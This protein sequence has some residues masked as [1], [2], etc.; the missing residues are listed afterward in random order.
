MLPRTSTT[1]SRPLRIGCLCEFPS[2]TGGEHSLLTAVRALAGQLEP[3]WIAP[4]EGRLAEA[5][6]AHGW[7][8][9][10][11]HVRDAAGRRRPTPDLLRELRRLLEGRPLDLLHANSLSMGRLTGA[12]AE[13]ILLPRTAHLRD[14][15]TL[16]RQAV[17]DLNAN[18]RLAAVSAATRDCHL[19]QG[20]D[21]QRVEVLYNGVDEDC[22]RPP[23]TNAERT[24][25]HRELHLPAETPLV[26]AVGQI[27]LRKGWDV[28]AATAPLIAAAVPGVH[29]VLV[30]ERSSDK[31]ETVAFEAELHRLFT[32]AG[33][34]DR[35]HPLGHRGDVPALLR[36]ATVLVHP[37]RQEPFGRV[38]LEAAAT[39][40]PIVA[41]AVGGTPEMLESERSALLVPPADPSALAEGVIRLLTDRALAAIL[42]AAAREQVQSRFPC[43]ER[44][45]DL[46]RFWERTCRGSGPAPL[47]S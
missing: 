47:N 2:L 28:L 11:F 7:P 27:S 36:S 40:L 16:S 17:R 33:L 30:G 5:L 21:P 18:T 41:A 12:L 38:L 23:R 9:L 25:L 24:S 45:R 14:I 37:A 6:A 39:G 31:P 3:V 8:H 1:P 4:T 26:L 32:A 10:P 13:W 29:F 43:R 22:F 46:W 34:G 42:G 44:A 35:F 20:L 19:A 15:V